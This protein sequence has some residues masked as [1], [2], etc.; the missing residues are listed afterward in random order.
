MAGGFAGE[1]LALRATSGSSGTARRTRP[2]MTPLP[3]RA[4]A[5]KACEDVLTGTW[6]AQ[7]WRSESSAWD[8]V[9]LQLDRHGVQLSGWITVE[10]WRGEAEQREPPACDDGSPERERWKERLSGSYHA[11]VIDIRGSRVRKLNDGCERGGDASSYRLDHFTGER[12]A[13][14]ELLITTNDDGGVDQGRPHHFQ[15][16][17]CRP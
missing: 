4:P 1:A 7:V 5:K 10:T 12:A 11:G 6:R 8:L 2:A 14:A 13:D 16:V 9:T 3:A 15:R 17:S